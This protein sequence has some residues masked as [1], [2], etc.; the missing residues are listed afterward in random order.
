MQASLGKRQARVHDELHNFL[1]IVSRLRH[2]SIP[3]FDPPMLPAF[4]S[5]VSSGRA[6][7]LCRNI[8][9]VVLAV[10]CFVAR[11]VIVV[12][13]ALFIISSLLIYCRLAI[14]CYLFP[15]LSPFFPST[16]DLTKEAYHLWGSSLSNLYVDISSILES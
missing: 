4:P 2:T 14:M 7:L 10:C 13:F 11:R 15:I 5:L 16:F 12:T 1:V 6:S 9:A 8:V 3:Q